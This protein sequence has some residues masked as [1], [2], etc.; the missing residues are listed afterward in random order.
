[1]SRATNRSSR[2]VR[3][4]PHVASDGQKRIVDDIDGATGEAAP[5]SAEA[6]ADL[7]KA[8]SV[9]PAIVEQW[10]AARPDLAALLDTERVG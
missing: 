7:V 4:G 9:P 2:S 5:P 3:A 10:R 6:L 1:M 8:G